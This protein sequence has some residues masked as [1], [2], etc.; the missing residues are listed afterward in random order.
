MCF[1]T[2]NPVFFKHLVLADFKERVYSINRALTKHNFG[3]WTVNQI[4][5]LLTLASAKE[6]RVQRFSYA[7]TN[8][9]CDNLFSFTPL[10]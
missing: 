9:K 5:Y 10:E 3:G 4:F 7:G 6:D 1:G 8:Q 2:C